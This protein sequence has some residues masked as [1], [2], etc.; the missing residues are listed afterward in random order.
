MQ[1]KLVFAT[2]NAHKITELRAILGKRRQ[3][4]S[5]EEIGCREEIPETSD[6]IE[7]NALQ[8]ARW[9]SQRFHCDCFADDTG[10]EVEALGGQPGVMSARYASINGR[11]EGHDASANSALL[12]EKLDGIENRKARFRTVIAAIIGGKEFLA[13]GIVNG[14]IA[15]TPRG[16]DGFGYDPLFIP[17][18]QSLTFAEM[19]SDEKNAISH[20]RR[21][22]EALL[23]IL[24]TNP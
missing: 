4:V 19:T 5:L 12:L 14:S 16:T 20:R 9:V 3:I 7:G 2:N 22:S 13:E 11:G 17:E 1:E 6:T 21:A 23:K 10:L 15:T 18:G 8:K 24:E